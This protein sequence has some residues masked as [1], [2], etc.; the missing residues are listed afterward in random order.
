MVSADSN[1]ERRSFFNSI[2]MNWV[3]ATIPLILKPVNGLVS[4][5]S[6]KT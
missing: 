2:G 5:K 6:A 4:I 3:C 1:D